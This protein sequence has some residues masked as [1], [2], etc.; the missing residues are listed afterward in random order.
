MQKIVLFL[1]MVVVFSFHEL[2][3]QQQKNIDP[4]LDEKGNLYI[5]RQDKAFLIEI[6]RSLS[7]YPPR[8]PL[9]RERYLALL[10]LD[11]VLHDPYAAFRMPVQD[12]FHQRMENVLNQLENTKVKQGAMIWKLYNMGFIIRTKT[13]TLAFDLVRGNSSRSKNFALSDEIMQRFVR[14]CDLLFISHKHYDHVD[15]GVAKAFIEQGKPVV[16]LPQVWEN[17]DIYP[18]I[19]HLKRD[20]ELMQ[21]LEIK[22]G[23][24]ELKVVVYPGHQMGKTENNV[25]LVFTPEGLSFCQMGDQ[26]NEGDF[27]VDYDWIDN[28]HK[29]HHI[30]VLMPPCWTNEI[31]RIVKGFDPQLVIP[32]HENELGHPVDDRVPFWGDSE[33][34]ELTYPELKKSDYP[35]LLMTWG[36]SYHYLP[37]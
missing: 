25:A 6:N 5:N 12:F 14:Q 26:I 19:T 23:K 32:G 37:K 18:Q 30:D 33:F 4:N 21:K 22:N 15:M 16:A 3:A 35:L 31:Y 13:V 36:E 9:Q 34:L 11:A 10:L 24:K 28:V 29:N 17:K 7:D 27:M 2:S 20:A 8:Y 1:L